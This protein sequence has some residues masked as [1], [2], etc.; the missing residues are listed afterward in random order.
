MKIL[1]FKR[2]RNVKVKENSSIQKQKFCLRNCYL[3]LEN[4]MMSLKY[5]WNMIILKIKGKNNKMERQSTVHNFTNANKKG[6]P[7]YAEYTSS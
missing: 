6:K 5:L 7:R 3:R 4:T 2:V 1:P